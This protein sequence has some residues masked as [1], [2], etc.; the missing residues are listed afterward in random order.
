MTVF[1]D[2]WTGIKFDF[3]N[4][5]FWVDFFLFFSVLG[6]NPLNQF[7]TTLDSYFDSGSDPDSDLDF[8]PILCSIPIP[9]QIT[10]PICD[11]YLGF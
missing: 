1:I 2:I 4:F 7:F 11:Y 8:V 6:S 10:I 9:I 3:Y 5:W